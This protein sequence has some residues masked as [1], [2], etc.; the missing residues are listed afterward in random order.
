[1]EN[2]DRII[3]AYI[4]MDK[5]RKNENLETMEADAKLHPE[6]VVTKLRLVVRNNSVK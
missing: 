1:M 2:L 3:A 4:A 5:R 6:K